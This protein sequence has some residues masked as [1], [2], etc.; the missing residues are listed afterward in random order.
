MNTN[1]QHVTTNN[2]K[3][4]AF[5]QVLHLY[6]DGWKEADANKWE[7]LLAWEESERPI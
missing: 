5:S 6:F 2:E 7:S 1:L 4:A 3:P